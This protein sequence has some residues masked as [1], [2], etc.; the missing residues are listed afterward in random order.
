MTDNQD[1]KPVDLAQFIT[2]PHLKES[3]IADLAPP[4]D[5]SCLMLKT[6]MKLV[7]K[8][9]KTPMIMWFMMFAVYALLVVFAYPCKYNTLH[10]TKS[11]ISFVYLL[12][13]LRRLERAGLD[14][15]RPLHGNL[16]HPHLQSLQGSR[17]PAKAQK[18]HFL[19][20]DDAV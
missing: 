13:S 10:S 12:I 15:T 8:S 11:L 6:P 1:R 18:H 14:P 17:V 19:A 7:K 3:L 5:W 4:K 20:D 2:T 9:Y 16:C